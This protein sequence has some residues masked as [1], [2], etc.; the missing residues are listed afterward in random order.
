M[1]IGAATHR[2][3]EILRAGGPSALFWKTLGEL[4]YRR[5]HLFVDDLQKPLD[6]PEARVPLEYGLL[7]KRGMDEYLALSPDA[8]SSEAS[9]R[10]A[11]GHEC[12][13]A[14]HEG[15][16]AGYCWSGANRAAV[17]YL[18]LELQLEPH[19]IYGYE[20]LVDP[21]LRRQRVS[22]GILSARRRILAE[23]GHRYELTAVMPENKPAYGFQTI[24]RRQPAGLLAVGWIGPW[25]RP[26]VRVEPVAPYPRFTV[27]ARSP[28]ATSG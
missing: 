17:G 3:V 4:C 2:T 18:G 12:V 15:R 24:M 22:V 9:R 26:I 11:D 16:L 23:I 8:S 6:L 13:T 5:V 7:D 10:L 14:H 20:L 27:E 1:Q 25:K 19:W 28:S 21:A